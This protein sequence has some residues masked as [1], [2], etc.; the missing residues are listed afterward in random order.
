MPLEVI[1]LIST[2]FERVAIYIVGPIKPSS[3]RGNRFIL[4]L[5][6]VTT[7]YLEVV[8]VTSIGT[9]TIAEALL[10]IFSKTGL[11]RE[12]LIDNRSQFT[13]H[14]MKELQRLLSIKSVTASL[15]HAQCNGLIEK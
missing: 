2:P 11:L 9:I 13:S 12:I 6:D 10:G 3:K 4:T 7:H 8:A 5:I 15:Y 1:P 14:M